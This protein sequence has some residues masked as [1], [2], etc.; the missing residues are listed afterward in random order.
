VQ[1]IK[2]AH[3]ELNNAPHVLAIKHTAVL[4][5]L[6]LAA[7]VLKLRSTGI[8][9]IP[10]QDVAD[11]FE[12]LCRSTLGLQTRQQ[13]SRSEVRDMCHRLAR[14]Q[15]LALENTNNEPSIRMNVMV[16]DAVDAIRQNEDDNDAIKIANVLGGF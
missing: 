16:E 15:I 9:C 14:I 2:T 12:G 11:R 10:F 6:F 13:P 7:V 1:H 5:R 4:E 3:T 8:E